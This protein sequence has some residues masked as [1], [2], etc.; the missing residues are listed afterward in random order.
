MKYIKSIFAVSI[1]A[2]A[3][4]G[5]ARAS[6]VSQTN[7]VGGSNVS[8][9][10]PPSGTNA[11]K[12]VIS[13]TDTNTTYT[14]G[15][16]TYSGT[17]KLYTGTGSATDGTLTQKAITDALSG[18]LSTS[19]T[20]A[21]ATADASG[22]TITSTYATKTELGGKQ[23]KSAMVDSTSENLSES[24]DTNYPTVA[25][26]YT[27]AA[28]ALGTQVNNKLDK[29]FTGDANKSKAVIT[30][31]NG[32]ITTGT[33]SSAMITDGA[34][35]SAKI[36]D[37]TIATADLS[38][39]SVTTAKIADL[40]VTEGKIAANAVTTAKIKDANVTT[41]KVA[42]GAITSAKI[43]NGT[44]AEADL[45]DAVK[46][47]LNATVQ[48]FN[49]ASATAGQYVTHFTKKGTTVTA[50]TAYVQIPVGS[51]TALTGVASIWVE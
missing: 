16:T 30:D 24:N 27:I 31:A 45:S 18:K 2:M 46:T 21:K 34:V 22:N 20:A 12:V 28:N 10:V 50:E 26:V 25:A 13:A 32:A 51:A 36:A 6:I 40:N 9:T 37:G 7:I 5:N 48:T 23:D 8:V 42:D 38:G 29:K 4:V 19:G 3:V 39:G 47:K 49:P 15:T 14:T 41:A 1:V 44:I 11:G 17:T 43:A 35:T 33:I